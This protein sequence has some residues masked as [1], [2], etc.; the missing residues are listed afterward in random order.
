[1]K[2]GAPAMPTS[3]TVLID[4]WFLINC[5]SRMILL[6][7]EDVKGVSRKVRRCSLVGTLS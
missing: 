3:Q 4:A 5:V 2:N 6:W 1:M 7:R